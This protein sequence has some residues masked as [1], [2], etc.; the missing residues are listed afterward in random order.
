[1]SGVA[2]EVDAG[3]AAAALE[4]LDQDQLGQL[5]KDI[6]ALVEDQTKLRI[7]D[8]KTA[9]DGS[10]W[11][12]WSPAYAATRQA[13]HSLLVSKGNPGL[14]TSIQSYSTGLE[15]IVGTNLVYGPVHQFGSDDGAIPARPYL[16]LSAE[17]RADVEALVTTRV[18]ELLA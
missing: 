9:S 1:M 18:E 13:R 12:A 11:S 2:L 4:R 8:G 14:L 16:G 3:M 5:V 10:A 15:A 7:A 17:D 6:G